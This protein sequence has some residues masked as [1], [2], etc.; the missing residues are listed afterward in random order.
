[1]KPGASAMR[2]FAA[3]LVLLSL[4][5]RADPPDYNLIELVYFHV[6][7]DTTGVSHGYLANG[8]LDIG[9]GFF[10]EATGS[11]VSNGGV[12]GATTVDSY[13]GGLGYRRSFDLGDVFL[14]V[15]YLHVGTDTPSGNTGQSGY[16]WVWGLR[17][18]VNDQLE[19]NTGVEKSSV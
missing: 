2:W 13:L 15:D 4:P 7:S 18:T 10:G 9:Q 16:R 14:S 8:F 5:A 3:C 11:H 19:L 12:A 17:S 6:D 1:M